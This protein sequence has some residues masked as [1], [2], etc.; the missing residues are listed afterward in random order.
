LRRVFYWL[1]RRLADNDVILNMAEFALI[2]KQV[3]HEIINNKSTFPFLRTEVGYVGFKRVGID[4]IRQ[5]R[6][7][8]KTH[9]NFIGMSA[10]AIGGILSSS[11]YL[12]RL[13]A[14]IGAGLLPLNIILL[15]VTWANGWIH[16]F[17]TLVTLDL[18]YLIFFMAVISVYLARIYK[19]GVGRPLFVVNWRNSTYH[20]PDY[21][22][23]NGGQS[24]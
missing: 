16:A 10:F 22:L 19:N 24:S 6:A 20:H 11:T 3:R 5:K 18:M 4:Y 14:F 9:Y 7:Y 17:P 23:P 12:L 8:G 13:A 15:M 21:S 1:L 2:T